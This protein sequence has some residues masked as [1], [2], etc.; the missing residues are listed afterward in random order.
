M[1]NRY[2]ILFK[3]YVI[4]GETVYRLTLRNTSSGGTEFD[5]PKATLQSVY[6]F[7]LN[8]F[9]KTCFFCVKSRNEFDSF[10][11]KSAYTLRKNF[12]ML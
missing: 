4:L 2:P 6:Y 3:F 11:I 7:V 12:F 9:E 10:E 5:S 1:L 8:E